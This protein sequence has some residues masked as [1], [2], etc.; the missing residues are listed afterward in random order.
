MRGENF[1]YSPFSSV[2]TGSPPL[3]RGKLSSKESRRDLGRITPACAG[4]TRYRLNLN[5]SSQDHP[6]LRGEN[7]CWIMISVRMVGSPPLARGKQIYAS[8][9]Y[10]SKGITP[11]CAGKT[12][13]FNCNFDIC[14]DHPRLRGENECCFDCDGLALGSPPL[15]RGKLRVS[16]AHG[17]QERITPACAGKTYRTDYIVRVRKDHPRLRGENSACLLRTECRKGSPPLA[18]GKHICTACRGSRSRITPACA[19][20]TCV[21]GENSTSVWDHPRLRGENAACQADSEGGL[22]SPPLARG[23]P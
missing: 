21:L 23:K 2:C 22:G 18:R 14:Q 1:V 17:V 15:A 13:I 9:V 16:S 12:S 4:K 8:K 20:K 11:A 6:R 10:A 7:I 19:G 5:T 3:A